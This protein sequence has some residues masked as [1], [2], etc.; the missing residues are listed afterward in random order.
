[1]RVQFLHKNQE[2]SISKYIQIMKKPIALLAFIF[3]FSTTALFAQEEEYEAVKPPSTFDRSRLVFGGNAGASFADGF[4]FIRFSP[5]VGYRFTDWVT[6][7]GGINFIYN[8]QA[9]SIYNYD[10]ARYK[11]GYAGL[12]VFGRVHPIS[13]LFLMAQP[14]LNYRWGKL[15]FRGDTYPDEKEKGAFV[16]SLLVGG[17]AIL[18]SGGRGT[19]LS[20]Q[21]DVL[22]N[23]KTPYGN[24][25]FLNIGY[26]F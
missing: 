4:T 22:N 10:D 24:K 13:F 14:E 21:Y 5:Q 9:I 8:S 18:G 3:F 2:L 16:P 23:D 26:I 1:M 25:W 17:G 19:A 11:L 15:D 20:L 7:G 12:N 6:L